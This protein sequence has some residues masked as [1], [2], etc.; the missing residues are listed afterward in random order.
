MLM[1]PL[2]WFN[3]QDVLL[4]NYGGIVIIQE[5]Q[6]CGR[7]L[8]DIFIGDDYAQKWSEWQLHDATH[9]DISVV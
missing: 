6:E 8:N 5:C 3:S 4:I 2:F 1:Q 9:H 7:C